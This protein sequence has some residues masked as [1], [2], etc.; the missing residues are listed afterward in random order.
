M[1]QFNALPLYWK[2]IIIVGII[3]LLWILWRK[4]GYKLTQARNVILLPGETGVISPNK[5]SE[6]ESLGQLLYN[7]IYDTPVTGHVYAPYIAAT[8][9]TDNELDYLAKYYNKYLGNGTSLYSDIDSQYYI[10]SGEPAKLQARLAA[11]GQR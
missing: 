4:F 3:I 11:M 2:I 7:D 5:R 10:T 1:S 8:Q 6:I 9:L